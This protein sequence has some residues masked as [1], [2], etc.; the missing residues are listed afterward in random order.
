[1]SD[2]TDALIKIAL[3]GRRTVGAELAQRTAEAEILKFRI[4]YF[5]LGGL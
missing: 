2:T 1:M 3:G 4:P 5:Y